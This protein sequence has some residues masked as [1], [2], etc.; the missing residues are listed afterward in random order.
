VYCTF[1]LFLPKGEKR[2]SF[3]GA[4]VIDNRDKYFKNYSR[5]LLIQVSKESR[6]ADLCRAYILLCPYGADDASITLFL[7]LLTNSV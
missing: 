1:F 6:D 3:S 2:C 4:R 7:S 5:A